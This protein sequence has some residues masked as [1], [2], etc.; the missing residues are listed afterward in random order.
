MQSSPGSQEATSAG[1]PAALNALAALAIALAL[2]ISSGMYDDRALAL[3]GLGV[4]AAVI[5]AVWRKRGAASGSPLPAQAILGAGA[6]AGLATHLVANPT[7]YGD[8]SKLL[9]FRWLAVMSLVILSAYLCVHLRPSLIRARFFLLLACFVLMGI[10]VIRASPQPWM[11]VWIVQQKAPA[12][13]L[14]G[15]NPYSVSYPNIYGNLSQQF[16]A[17][18]VVAGNRLLGYPYPPLAILAALPGVALL[19]DARY[20]MLALMALAS[21]MLARAFPTSSTA[22]LAGLFVLFQ[23]RTFFVLEQAWVEPVMLASFALV[24]FALRRPL[25]AG[26]GLGLLLVSKQYSPYLAVPLAFALPAR[27][28]LRSLVV[29][30]M[31]AAAMMLPFVLWDWRGFFRGVIQMQIWQPF[32]PDSLSVASLA[33][34]LGWAH[35]PAWVGPVAGV[36]G[37]VALLRP[38]IRIA[39]ACS[40]A[41]ASFALVLVSYKQSS[42]NFWWLCGALSCLAAGAEAGTTETTTSDEAASVMLPPA[43]HSSAD[44][45]KRRSP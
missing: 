10:A 8:Q 28:R 11:D 26:L 25:V 2:H 1:G 14:R 5:A 45:D 6:A 44:V 27:D 35:I 30:A 32:R 36:V 38:G 15:A 7:F 19:G 42:A 37:L 9:G 4:A 40:I 34:R 24:L 17:P 43:D 33:T 39:Q 12:A 29:A 31:V 21:W 22:E 18:Q 16:Y 13:L 3:A 23:P 41:A 20:S